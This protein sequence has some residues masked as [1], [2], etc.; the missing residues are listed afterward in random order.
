M[1]LEPANYGSN[2]VGR[3]Q[4]NLSIEKLGI[5]RSDIMGREST[6]SRVNNVAQ[7][8]GEIRVKNHV[9]LA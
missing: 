9:L 4:I 8:I 5:P 1:E 7:T 2:K 6:P 3:Y